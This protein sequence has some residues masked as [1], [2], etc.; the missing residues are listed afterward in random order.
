MQILLRLPVVEAAVG[1]KRSAIYGRI[2]RGL[3][4]APVELGP[5]SVAW[6]K[7]EVEIIVAAIIQGASEAE[8]RAEVTKLHRVRGYQP[9]DAKRAKYKELVAKRRKAA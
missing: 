5:R 6:V 9:D 2:A 8:L 7:T 1:L 4:P 3:F